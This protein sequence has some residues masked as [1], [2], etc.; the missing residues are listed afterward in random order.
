MKVI[1]L[2]QPKANKVTL[3][4]ALERIGKFQPR[5]IASLSDDRLAAGYTALSTVLGMLSEEHP[6]QEVVAHLFDE[7]ATELGVRS[8]KAKRSS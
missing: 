6:A 4:V 8:M 1:N 5:R 2:H 7:F 3:D